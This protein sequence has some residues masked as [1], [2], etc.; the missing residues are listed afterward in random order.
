MMGTMTAVGGG[1]IRDILVSEIPA[2][3]S[4]DFYATAA[5]L[6]AL[7]LW[8]CEVLG[9][10][11]EVSLLVGAALTIGLRLLAMRLKM[12][13]PRVHNLPAP[14]AELA[15]KFRLPWKRHKGG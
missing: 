5:A 3:L 11:R 7:S 12:R 15:K 2:V 10:G 4:S 8:G 14:P 13:L 9:L 1:V 6:G